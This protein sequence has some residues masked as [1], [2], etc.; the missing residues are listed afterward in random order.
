MASTKIADLTLKMQR[1]Y[2]KFQQAMSAAGLEFKV[3]CTARNI[4]EQIALYAQGREVLSKTNSLRNKVGLPPITDKDN[5]KK[6]TW[7]L[8]SKHI[9]DNSVTKASAFDIVLLS[10]SRPTW[11]L[12][13]NVNKNQVPDYKEAADIGE[14]V[15]LKAGANFKTPD[16]PHF[17]DPNS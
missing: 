13:I 8:Q 7:T 6:V 16:Y 3:T 1:L 2:K 10:N 12:K 11:D 9:V 4:E 5:K 14:S 15:G 17:E